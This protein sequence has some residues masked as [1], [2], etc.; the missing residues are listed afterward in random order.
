MGNIKLD[1]HFSYLYLSYTF[2]IAT[3][4]MFGFQNC[5]MFII[6]CFLSFLCYYLF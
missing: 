3:M 6:L 1:N 5:F 2:K 4:I